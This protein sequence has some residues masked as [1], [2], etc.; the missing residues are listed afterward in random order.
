ME[1]PRLALKEI[2]GL[3]M[4]NPFSLYLFIIAVKL[5]AYVRK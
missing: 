2:E 3:G 4:E 1:R 5:F